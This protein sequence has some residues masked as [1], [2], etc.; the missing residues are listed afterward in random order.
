MDSLKLERNFS[1]LKDNPLV[2]L[3]LLIYKRIDFVVFLKQN[4]LGMA[5]FIKTN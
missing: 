3:I 1:S 2:F 5:L 4:A